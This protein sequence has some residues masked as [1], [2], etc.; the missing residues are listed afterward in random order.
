MTATNM[1]SNLVVNGIVPPSNE[2]N[3]SSLAESVAH[4]Q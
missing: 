1:C 4:L 2:N 3:G